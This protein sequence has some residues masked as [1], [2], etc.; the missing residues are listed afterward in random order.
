MKIGFYTLGC[1]VNQ[2]ETQALAQLAAEQG[3]ELTEK[4]ADIFII[5]TCTVTSVSDRKNLRV[6]HKI[7]RENPNAVIAAC[8]CFAQAAPEKVLQQPEI[9]IICGTT[10]RAGV[11]AVCEQALMERK[12]GDFVQKNN[13][14]EVFEYLPAGILPGHTRALLK[15]QDGCDNYCAYCIIPYTR[16][17]V[18]S[19]PYDL[20][21]SEA[22][23]LAKSGVREIILTGIEI[24]SYGRDLTPKIDLCTLV[25]GICRAAPETRIRLG[26]LEPRTVTEEF[27]QTLSKHPNLARHF[28]LSLQSGSDAV[29]KRMNRRYTTEEFLSFVSLLRQYFQDCSITT[30]LITGF[31]NETQKEFDETIAFIKQ[32]AFA[33]IHVFPYSVRKRTA[34]AEMAGQLPP[35]VK[36]ARADEVKGIAKKLNHAFLNRFIGKEIQ[37]LLEHQTED[38]VWTGHS[39]W[40]FSVKVKTIKGQKNSMVPVRIE[41]LCGE[42]LLAQALDG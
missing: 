18:R 42:A 8:G 16:G 41:K 40:H 30:D 20:A 2:F 37:V 11:L 9:D 38:Q 35:Q 28:H 14:K 3:Y 33:Q 15:V 10:D 27:C 6:F 34:A 12:K 32:C 13:K 5:N 19:M 4:D 24:S 1:K 17:H 25:D 22:V 23:R 31:P 39:L 21:L 29:L 7:R 36:K 26:S